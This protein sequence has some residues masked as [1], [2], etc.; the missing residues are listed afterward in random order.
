MLD[1][2]ISYA[3][4]T[5][6]EA[7]RMAEALRA[8]G[9]AI[10]R[11]DQ[12]P[13]HRPYADVIEE[14]LRT[15]KAV[16][17]IWSAEAVKSQWVRAEA[18]FARKAGSL[19]QLS[20]DG[21]TPPLPFDQI[22]CVDM[23][24]WRGDPA[25]QAWR[26]V[27]GSIA[28][29]CQSQPAAVP[30]RPEPAPAAPAKPSI[31]VLPFDN[32]SGDPEQGYFSDGITE[33]IITDLGKVSALRVTARNTVF[34]FKGQA[35]DVATVA[36]QLSVSHVLE[37]SVRK[38][39]GRVRITAQLIDGTSGDHV[40]AERY[41]RDL[42]DIFEL[43][44]EISK[45]IV[46][47]LR[48]KLLPEEKRAIEQRGT[49]NLE[50]FNLYL[51][52][53]QHYI[54]GNMTDRAKSETVIRLCRRAIEL[55]PDYARAWAQLA[56]G[57][58]MALYGGREG[59]NGLA[60]AER[61]LALDDSLADAHAARAAVLLG[62]GA[63]DEARREVETAFRLDLDCYEA[64]HTA[65]KLCFAQGRHREAIDFWEKASKVM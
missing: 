9:Y 55:D 34:T 25:A 59:D 3:R 17:V 2:F 47:A 48:L 27:V 50:A 36:R 15:A 43:Q 56:V 44:D 8:S 6:A 28:E 29:L 46:A 64:N 41:D 53:R 39:G 63:H 20:L 58:R 51:M 45:A 26:T 19:V 5:A 49:T 37:G 65:G 57:Q 12:L 54:T 10:W 4:S 24:A 40:W 30:R 22:Q 61:A 21:A 62:A 52:A 31:A 11:D 33:D 23:S 7:D 32:M 18:D 16:L 13:A 42:T 35:V 60:A 1:V 38:A 14:R